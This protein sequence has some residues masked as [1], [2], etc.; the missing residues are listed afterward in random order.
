MEERGA[1]LPL[2]QFEAQVDEEKMQIWYA[3]PRSSWMG[4]PSV[5]GTEEN[6][7]IETIK[8]RWV[9]QSIWKDKWDKMAAGW[10]RDI[11]RWKHEEPLE[12]EPDSET[13]MEA[14]TPVPS[15]SFFG[16]PQKQAQPKLRRP[17]SDEEKRRI[18]ERQVVREREREASRPYHQFIY[19][20]STERKRIQDEYA[21]GDG[22]DAADIN[23]RAYENIKTVWTKRGMWNGRWG[24]LPGIVEARRAP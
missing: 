19:Q 16:I 17:K 20:I 21:D 3:D 5:G 18:A 8:K 23:T 13:D 11:G 10:Y 12:L 14:E 22:A 7:A 2:Q 6:K 15:F 24:I 4:E 1:S 9:E